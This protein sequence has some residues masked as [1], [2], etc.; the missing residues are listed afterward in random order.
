MSNVLAILVDVPP[1]MMGDVVS[2]FVKVE[3]LNQ[4]WEVFRAGF[5]CLT[6]DLNSFVIA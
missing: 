5:I 6:E 3:I 1:V 4:E 2:L